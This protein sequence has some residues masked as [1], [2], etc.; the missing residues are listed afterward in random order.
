MIGLFFIFF[1]FSSRRRHTRLQGDW[2]SDVCSS[3][4]SPRRFVAEASPRQGS[5]GAASK[6]WMTSEWICL[7]EISLRSVAPRADWKRRRFSRTFSLVS[8]SAKPRLRAFSPFRRLTPPRRVL[9]PWTSQGSFASA[10]TCR[11][12]MPR[13]LRSIQSELDRVEET[14][15][16]LCPTEGRLGTL[17]LG[18]SVFA[19]ATTLTV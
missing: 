4:L 9:K 2:S 8:H 13:T 7:S 15:K 1:F 6:R 17:R 10:G 14:D 18:V 19:G 12:R 16:N 11:I 5:A 3:D